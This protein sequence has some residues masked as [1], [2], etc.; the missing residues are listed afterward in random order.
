MDN[1]SVDGL[2]GVEK[3]ENVIRKFGERG[4]S[5]EWVIG[6]INILMVFKSYLK[7]SYCLYVFMFLRCLDYCSM[8]V[9][10]DLLE[11]EFFEECDYYYDLVCNDC[12][13]FYYLESLMK[14]VFL[15]FEV[16][17]YSND[18]KEDKLYDV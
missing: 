4:K 9:L 17:F 10:S 18:E 13:S 5:F 15:D 14:N 8:F 3:F 12:E 11:L 7:D 1:I 6:V 2:C 16:V